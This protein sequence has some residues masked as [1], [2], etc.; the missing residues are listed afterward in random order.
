MEGISKA[1]PWHHRYT[2]GSFVADSVVRLLDKSASN[3]LAPF[4]SPM[5]KQLVRLRRAF[6]LDITNVSDDDGQFIGAVLAKIAQRGFPAPCSIE[7]E[8]FL[9]QQAQS[10]DLLTWKEQIKSGAFVFQV[11]PNMWDLPA[12]L[13]ACYFAELLLE[14][15]EVE[16]LLDYYRTL[17]TPPEQKFFDLVLKFCNDPRL[18][19]Y[20]TPQRLMVTMV[21]LTRPTD[22]LKSLGTDRRVDFAVELPVLGNNSWL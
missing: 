7:L 16:A 22:E 1:C 20:I 4:H 2:V 14:D 19:L 6:T 15:K 3:L 21:R 5:L 10:A 9:L 17:C 18:A 12:L 8:R 13:K 11:Q